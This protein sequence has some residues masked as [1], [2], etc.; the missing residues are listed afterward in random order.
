MDQRYDPTHGVVPSY[1]CWPKLYQ[2]KASP[3]QGVLGCF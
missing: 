3:I 2:A 1:L